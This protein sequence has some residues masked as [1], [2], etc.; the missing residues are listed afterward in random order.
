MMAKAIRQQQLTHNIRYVSTNMPLLGKS[1]SNLACN[2][3]FLLCESIACF[4]VS[5]SK[6]SVRLRSPLLS[7]CSRRIIRLGSRI[8]RE[9][10]FGSKHAVELGG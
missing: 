1:T 7:H 9:T 3:R 8:A 6:N 5:F 2:C 10:V 4:G